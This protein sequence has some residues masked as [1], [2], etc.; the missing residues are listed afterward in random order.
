MRIGRGIFVLFFA[1]ITRH[2]VVLHHQK[3]VFDIP[4]ALKLNEEVKDAAKK[5]GLDSIIT[6]V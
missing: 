6:E 4:G 5:A 2:S 1:L 3:R